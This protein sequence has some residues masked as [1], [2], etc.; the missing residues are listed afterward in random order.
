MTFY[1]LVPLFHLFSYTRPVSKLKITS[2]IKSE[3]GSYELKIK[4]L[5]N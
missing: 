5:K 1:G 4:I 3:F 2:E